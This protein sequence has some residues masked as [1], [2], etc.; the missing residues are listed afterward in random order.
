MS[1]ITRRRFLEYGAGAGA[2]MVLWRSGR[3]QAF[4]HEPA[5][6]MLDPRSIPKYV[7]PLVIPPAM[8]RTSTIARQGRPEHR[9]LRDRRAPVPPAHPAAE[10]GPAGR[11]RSG[12]TGRST[13][14]ARSTT[15]R[16]R[17]RRAGAGRSASSGSTAWST[18]NGEFLPHLLPVDQTLHWA[19][20]P[21]GAPG[22][23]GH[24]SDQAPYSGPVPIVTHLHGGHSSGGERRLPRGLVPAGRRATF[25]PGYARTGSHYQTF[26]A[27]AQNADSVRRGRPAAPCSSTTTTS[28]RRRCGTT[29]TRSG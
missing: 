15:R 9:L 22:R 28:A 27:Q 25:P 10:H 20:P 4:A 13:T 19:N 11:P 5:V 21:G 26:R 29:T 8:P 7:T 3:G 1:A 18:P 24:G 23:D 14:P 6:G 17:S 2:G 16:S 12:A